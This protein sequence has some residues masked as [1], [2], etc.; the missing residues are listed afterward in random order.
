PCYDLLVTARDHADAIYGLDC[1]P[2][3]DL[4][5]IGARDRHAV[6][7]IE[8]IRR[9]HPR[10]VIVVLFGESHLAP[11]H[12]PQLLRERMP[13]ERLLTVLQN[14]DA[15]YW[16]AA[17]E[18]NQPVPAVRVNDDVVCVFNSTPL[19][20]YES[21]RLYLTRWQGIASQP[22]AAPTIYNLIDSLA[23]FLDI[24]RYS[25]HNTTQPKFL[26]DLLPEVYCGFSDLRV[27]Q[28]LQRAIGD[29][30]EIEILLE[31]LE[32]CGCIY[33]A[34]I[35]TIYVRDFQ[36]MFTAEEVA[37]FLHHACR[38][39][40]HDRRTAPGVT[41]NRPEDLFYARALENAL[42]YFGSRVLYP[43]RP[44]LENELDLSTRSCTK[45]AQD[46]LAGEQGKFEECAKV[47]GYRMGSQLY[48]A[49]LRGVV[50]RTVLRRLFLAHI[51][52]PGVASQ[53]CRELL[54]RVRSS[55]KKPCASVR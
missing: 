40:P 34:S 38:G 9:I 29:P 45:L 52:E 55:S 1:M 50:S 32:S 51:D 6:E 7:K 43:P 42:G 54:R 10:A 53:L 41:S 49:Y 8:E 23:S 33:L 28:L 21:Y 20:K 14:V 22:D 26:V 19:E 13:E 37:R 27:H 16:A 30:Q 31:K 35:N 44:P 2:R 25:S 3:E 12:L 4:R 48:D 5:K 15:L 36:M 17:A 11:Y 24:N 46:G 39:L 18:P 47:L